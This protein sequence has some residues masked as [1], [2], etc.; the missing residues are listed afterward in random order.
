LGRREPIQRLG[1]LVQADPDRG[2]LKVRVTVSVGAPQ[3]SQ[4]TQPQKLA[5]P[6]QARSM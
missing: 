6:K 1:R 5:D 2:Y 4:F 3:V